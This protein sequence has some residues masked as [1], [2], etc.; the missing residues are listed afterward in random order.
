MFS[1]VTLESRSG[2][3]CDLRLTAITTRRMIRI[4]L[5]TAVCNGGYVWSRA[6]LPTTAISVASR[7]VVRSGC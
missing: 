6:I 7:H 2:R 4:A 5:A 3:W 1:L